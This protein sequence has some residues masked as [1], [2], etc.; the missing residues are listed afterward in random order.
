[1]EV[2]LIKDVEKLGRA[3]DGL[4]GLGGGGPVRTARVGAGDREWLTVYLAAG[5][6]VPSKWRALDGYRRRPE[7]RVA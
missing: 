2:I 3:A 6:G 5:F 7:H 4:V 1:M